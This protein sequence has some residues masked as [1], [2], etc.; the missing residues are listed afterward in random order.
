MSYITGDVFTL[1]T[2]DSLYSKIV[3][4]LGNYNRLS[5][6]GELLSISSLKSSQSENEKNWNFIYVHFNRLDDKVNM[7]VAINN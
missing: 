6:N 5:L 1:F 4:G 2:F 7:T 3:V